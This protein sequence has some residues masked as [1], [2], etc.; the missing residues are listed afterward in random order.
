ME[1]DN[2]GFKNKSNAR[3]CTK[4]GSPLNEVEASDS[5]TASKS[6]SKIIIIA[7]IIIIFILLGCI[8]FFALNN[9]TNTQE[10]PKNA[11]IQEDSSQNINQ[12]NDLESASISSKQAV[13][14]KSW[15]SIGKFS[16]SGS[17]FET[18]S[19][20][21]GKIMVKLSAYPIKNYATN[22]LY[23]SGSNGESGGVDWNSKSAVKT[24]SDS[25][26]YTSSSPVEFTIDYDET[27]SWNVE[28]FKY[29]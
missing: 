4:C 26:T 16:G 10:V 28:F 27:V 1:C 23:V 12:N 25:F 5:N 7:L 22:H 2:C 24:K 19:V 14:S 11:V 17:G 9:N 8:G 29:Q 15:K 6:N 13:E 18:V 21:E 20:P 3:Y